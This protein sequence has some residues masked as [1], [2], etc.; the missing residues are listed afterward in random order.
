ML[1]R[2]FPGD[3]PDQKALEAIE[4]LELVLNFSEPFRDDSAMLIDFGNSRFHGMA[5]CQFRINGL[6]GQYSLHSKHNR[7]R[8]TKQAD[9]CQRKCVLN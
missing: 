6:S 9:V 3:W 5:G 2:K 8:G 1:H 4:T 7:Y